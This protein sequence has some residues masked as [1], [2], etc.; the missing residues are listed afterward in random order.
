VFTREKDRGKGKGGPDPLSSTTP[1]SREQFPHLWKHKAAHGAAA[2]YSA[3]ETPEASM[4][5]E[6]RGRAGW[7]GVGQKKQTMSGVADV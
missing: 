1:A 2:G 6:R 3:K 4:R 7:E 5:A